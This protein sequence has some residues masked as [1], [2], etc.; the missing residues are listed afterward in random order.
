MIIRIDDGHGW[1]NGDKWINGGSVPQN[2]V[3]LY[4]WNI[5]GIIAMISMEYEE[6]GIYPSI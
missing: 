1:I 4:Q 3:R 2:M 5:N 6:D